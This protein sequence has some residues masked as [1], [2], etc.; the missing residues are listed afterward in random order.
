MDRFRQTLRRDLLAAMEA[1]PA[2]GL[3]LAVSF[4]STAAAVFAFLLV[5][6]VVEPDLPARLHA[7]LLGGTPRVETEPAGTGAVPTMVADLDLSV[8]AHLLEEKGAGARQDRA[9]L[10][11]WYAQRSRPTQVKALAGERLLALRQFELAN[12]E[13]VAVLTEV[14]AP[15]NIR[16]VQALPASNR[17]F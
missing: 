13:R 1:R 7:S 3:K 4:A 17:T 16:Q 6:F 15:R 11:S 14:G 2:R 9:F 10:E 8:L 5:A 12:G